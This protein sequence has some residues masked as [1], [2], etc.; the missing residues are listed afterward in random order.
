[1]C[2]AMKHFS[3]SK[4]QTENILQKIFK[5]TRYFYCTNFLENICFTK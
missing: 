1:M 2:V 5:G 3:I 4:D